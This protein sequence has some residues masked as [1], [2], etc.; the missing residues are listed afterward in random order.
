MDGLIQAGQL[1][2]SLSILVIFHEFGHFFFAKL[3]NTRVEKFYLFFDAWFSLFK[4]KKGDTEYGIGWIP[5]G[6]Y[7]KISG[8]IDESMDKEALEA[9]PQ[10]WEFRSKTAFQRLLIMLGGVVVNFIL[11]MAIFAMILYV[12]GEEYLPNDNVEYGITVDALGEEIGFQNGDKILSI[13]NMEIEKFTD[14]VPEIILNEQSSIQVNRGGQDMELTIDDEMISKIIKHKGPFL[15]VR[16]P[17]IINDFAKESLAK[18]AGMLIGDKIIGLNGEEINY[19]DEFSTKIKTLTENDIVVTVLRNNEKLDF[20][21]TLKE[22]KLIGVQALGSLSD[23]FELNK[24]EYGLI[25][26]IP[27][28]ISKGTDQMVNY[29]KQVKLMFRPDTEAYKSVGSFISIGKMF[30]AQWDWLV[31]WTWTAILSVMLGVLNLLP[32]P[33]LDGGHVMF[34]LFEIITGKK[35]SDKFMEYAQM[36]GMVLLLSLMVFAIGNDV[37]RHILN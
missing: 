3:F 26:A 33:A 29:V 37:Y 9:E 20:S 10:P 24:K 4:F 13:N 28:G 16:I 30:P 12:W 27:K 11:A 19:H 36:L 7:V 21:I 6:G 31:F 35:P 14:I 18:D 15:S 8:M 1:L 2:L 32:I 34:L 22:D 25:E 17:F 23:F 5:L